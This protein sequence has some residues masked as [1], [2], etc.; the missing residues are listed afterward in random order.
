MFK[1]IKKKKLFKDSKLFN[2]KILLFFTLA[3]SLAS[4]FLMFRLKNVELDYE[5]AAITK[6]IDLF[7]TENRDL[8][9]RKARLLSSENLKK[10]AWKL[11]FVEP[12][13]EKIIV[14]P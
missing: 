9:A 10:L 1:S 12:K 8:H 13:S 6:Q 2:S 5:I 4:L 7:K 11:G 14:V 3:I